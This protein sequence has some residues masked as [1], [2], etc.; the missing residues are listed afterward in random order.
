MAAILTVRKANNALRH[1]LPL[2]QFPVTLS[3][4]TLRDLCHV[5]HGMK[6]TGLFC[7]LF[8]CLF[9]CFSFVKSSKKITLS[10]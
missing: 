9:V 5:C 2:S 7:C 3:A 4:S 6:V 10:E 8:F 1:I